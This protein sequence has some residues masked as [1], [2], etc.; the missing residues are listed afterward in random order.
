M[1]GRVLRRNT[2]QAWIGSSLRSSPEIPDSTSDAELIY[3]VRQTRK[4]SRLPSVT[5][6]LLLLGE[7]L[8]PS[9]PPKDV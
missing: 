7:H 8:L 3:L 9:C 2:G 4:R 1:T 5:E 6:Y